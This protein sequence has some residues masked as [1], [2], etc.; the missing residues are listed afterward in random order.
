MK[1]R[2]DQQLHSSEAVPT[3]PTEP[4]SDWL[5]DW[6]EEQVIRSTAEEISRNDEDYA[7]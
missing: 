3:G 5:D 4:R 7:A 6:A 1:P 2:K